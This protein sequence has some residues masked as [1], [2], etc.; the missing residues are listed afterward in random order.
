MK[1]TSEDPLSYS[2]EMLFHYDYSITFMIRKLISFDDEFFYYDNYDVKV[3]KIGNKRVFKTRK[4]KDFLL[5]AEGKITV[6]GKENSFI[7]AYSKT[8]PVLL[9]ALKELSECDILVIRIIVKDIK[10][11]E[12][13]YK[14]FFRFGELL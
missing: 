13:L 11:S 7:Y 3:G 14:T 6:W 10:L 4:I 8:D 5:A 1:E 9:K 12:S 2:V